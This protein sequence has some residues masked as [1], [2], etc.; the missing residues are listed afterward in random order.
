MHREILFR[1]KRADTGE[2]V[3]GW[4]IQKRYGVYCIKWYDALRFRWVTS[5]VVTATIGQYSGMTDQ[6]GQK[7]FEGDYYS[8]GN[9]VEFS[10]GC[11]NINGDRLLSEICNKIMIIGNI[12]DK[13]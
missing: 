8:K 6:T 12:H 3:Q 13:S 10:F 4:L 1:G 9:I 2:W 5:E 7:I 11:F